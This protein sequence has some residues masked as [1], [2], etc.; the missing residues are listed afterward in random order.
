[1]LRCSVNSPK[2][3]TTIAYRDIMEF[4][5][6]AP[7]DVVEE[8]YHEA[9]VNA[10]EGGSS[11][12]VLSPT[13]AQAVSYREEQVRRI[14]VRQLVDSRHVQGDRLRMLSMLHP[15][16][17]RLRN[18]Q[19]SGHTS[20]AGSGAGG[21]QRGQHGSRGEGFRSSGHT[22]YHTSWDTPD[23][24][25]VSELSKLLQSVDIVYTETEL[26]YICHQI[27]TQGKGGPH[28]ATEVGVKLG[29]VVLYLSNLLIGAGEE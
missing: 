12:K 4:L 16:R 26:K 15:L 20:A 11:A 27:E 23:Y 22:S 7:A 8:A 6:N 2:D 19:S 13:K 9:K 21:S 24:C 25:T 3:T 18:M 14:L 29:A 5:D 17:V 28:Y 1:M 10:R